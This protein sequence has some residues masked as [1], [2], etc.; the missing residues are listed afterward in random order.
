MTGKIPS[1]VLFV[2]HFAPCLEF[3][4]DGLGLKLTRI[5]R[6]KEHPHWA[7]LEGGGISMALHAGHKGA[8]LKS[9]DPLAVQFLVKDI[10]KILSSV[11][12]HG[13]SIRSP[14]RK[15]DFR[16]A[17]L[18]LV[19]EA[20]VADPDGNEVELQQVIREYSEA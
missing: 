2:N 14:S 10:K 6:G 17:E 20:T 3:Y 19:Y 7:E 16:P 5:Y 18:R 15:I 11:E 9:A 1:L 13:G 12:L 8:K 4:R